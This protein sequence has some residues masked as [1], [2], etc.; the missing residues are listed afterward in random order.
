MAR[1]RE[2][3]YESVEELKKEVIKYLTGRSTE[4]ENAGFTKELSLFIKGLFTM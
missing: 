1:E 2:D 4:A 3:R